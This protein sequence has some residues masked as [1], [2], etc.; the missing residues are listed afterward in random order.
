MAYKSAGYV[1]GGDTTN[2]PRID[3]KGAS[4]DYRNESS[5][6]IYPVDSP[7][8][9]IAGARNVQNHFSL[10]GG[11]NLLNK[12]QYGAFTDLWAT[13]G[14]ATN[15]SVTCIA[16]NPTDQKL[17]LGTDTGKVFSYDG[18]SFNDESATMAVGFSSDH[19]VN[20]ILFQGANYITAGGKASTPVLNVNGVDK[21]ASITHPALEVE[22][23]IIS[24]DIS[25]SD[26]KAILGCNSGTDIIFYWDISAD[27]ATDLTTASGL[28]GVAIY[29][30]RWCPTLSKFMV[31]GGSRQLTTCD[32][33]GANWA[34]ITPKMDVAAD[35]LAIAD[36]ETESYIL[37]GGSDGEFNKY[38]GTTV[39]QMKPLLKGTSGLDIKC[40]FQY[41]AFEQTETKLKLT[42]NDKANVVKEFLEN[43]IDHMFWSHMRYGGNA[44]LFAMF[45]EK[46]LSESE[47]HNI[48]EGWNARI[49]I[50]GETGDW[51]DIYRGLI[52]RSSREIIL[53]KE[54]VN[55]LCVGYQHELR[56]IRISAT[57][58][59]KTVKEIVQA[60]M[61]IVVAATGIHISY[62]ASQ[63]EGAF[64]IDTIKF[65]HSAYEAI[66]IL[67]LIQGATEWGVDAQKKFY[68]KAQSSVVDYIEEVEKD[69]SFAEKNTD[70]C[71]RIINKIYFVGGAT[72]TAPEY[73][74]T[75][76]N[77][78]SQTT[79]GVREAKIYCSAI[80]TDTVAEQ[81]CQ[82]FLTSDKDI[83][84]RGMYVKDIT[85]NKHNW[86]GQDAP[87]KKVRLKI[88]DEYQDYNINDAMYIWLGGKLQLKIG[89]GKVE[90]SSN[91]M[92]MHMRTMINDMYRTIDQIR[93]ILPLLDA[94]FYIAGDYL[95]IAADS[96]NN[97]S[98]TSPFKVKEIKIA[99]GGT[100]RIKFDLKV[101]VSGTAYGQVYRNG[102][103]VGTL[104]SDTTGS[105]VTKSEDISGWSAGDLCQLYVHAAIGKSA[106]YKN[107]RLYS[108]NITSSI[109]I[110]EI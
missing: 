8:P 108:G 24:G 17:Y 53:N 84:E 55:I 9:V 23:E 59:G 71:N 20:V 76:E 88:K 107:F 60:I 57:Y 12:I 13:L 106:W 54:F 30:I 95:E 52:C 94:I 19:R 45:D 93:A 64:A 49:Q 5:K 42:L 62:N 89:A 40:I 67:A 38:D 27:A 26:D 70:D 51:E 7:N 16:Y 28:A 44:V 22:D 98:V 90:K 56:R 37:I 105:Y 18:A 97:K 43:K 100:L 4:C 72:A 34:D 101:Y 47:L 81:Y 77:G 87:I 3:L 66:N 10:I 6:I 104:Q 109:V 29:V 50:I 48:D 32:S 91:L 2:G 31:G 92:I 65:D 68:F 36:L 79:Y 35:I 73:T 11:K 74:K 15:K 110:S 78:D 63:I 61:D 39:F 1:C 99:Y 86:I 82:S 25:T 33:A 14:L 69:L 75:V 96:E 103:A 80:T 83:T 46:L 102:V 21:T 85:D 58:T 41:T